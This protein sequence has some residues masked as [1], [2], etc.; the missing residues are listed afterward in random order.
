MKFMALH[1]S[2]LFPIVLAPEEPHVY[3]LVRHVC[4]ISDNKAR[5]DEKV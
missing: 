2:K 4:T 5:R 1:I 3:M